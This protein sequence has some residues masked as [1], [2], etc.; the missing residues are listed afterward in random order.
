ME[1][2]DAELVRRSRAGDVGAFEELFRKY[3]KPIYSMLYRM[4]RSAEDAVDL[5][6]D[7][8]VQAYA[9]LG[10]LRN[11]A[12]FYAWLRQIAVN[13]A[14][15]RHKRLT[16]VRMESLDETLTAEEGETLS[17]QLADTAPSPESAVED[18]EL[19]W[20][21]EQAISELSEDHRT[22]VVLHHLEHMGVADIAQILGVSVGTVKSRL[23]RAREQLYK[24]L[25]AYV[26]PGEMLKS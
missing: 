19:R 7:A 4:V 10:T 6:Q 16:R 14:R 23:A 1:R 22:V 8:F 13:L 15:N 12:M 5:T 18:A 26:E 2:S 3:Q 20:R 25:T 11:E 9:Q 24:K 17:K 21:V